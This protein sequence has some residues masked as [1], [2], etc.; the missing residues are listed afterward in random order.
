MI[1]DDVFLAQ[2]ALHG[3]GLIGQTILPKTAIGDDWGR[4]PNMECIKDAQPR[5]ERV[6][7][8]MMQRRLSLSRMSSILSPRSQHSF[9]VISAASD[10]PSFLS[11]D[12]EWDDSEPIPSYASCLSA[13]SADVP[14][15]ILS[16]MIH[17][18]LDGRIPY[19]PVGRARLRM[20]R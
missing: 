3:I 8:C 20:S 17:V 7:Y 9:S 4:H 11:A 18:S 10:E 1:P 5:I 15:T 2:H 12:P 19:P 13:H 16:I 6:A 14:S